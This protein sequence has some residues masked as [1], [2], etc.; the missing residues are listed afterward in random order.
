MSQTGGQC[1]HPDAYVSATWGRQ[2]VWE[3]V[4]NDARGPRFKCVRCGYPDTKIISAKEAADMVKDA[5][6]R[7]NP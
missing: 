6:R 4:N 1:D 3:V 5:M 2:H 7:A